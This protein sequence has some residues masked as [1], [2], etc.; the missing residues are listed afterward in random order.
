[1]PLPI[2]NRNSGNV[3]RG[4]LNLQQTNIQVDSMKRQITDEVKQ[5]HLACQRCRIDLSLAEENARSEAA[6]S[7]AA[8][9]EYFGR[10]SPNVP[11]MN[12]SLE[13]LLLAWSEYEKVEQRNLE[14]LIQYL[15]GALELNTAVGER[16][17]P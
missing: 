13:S 16:I 8:E 7:R 14:I 6:R 9:R 5:V 15:R 1:M 2:Y 11:R 10:P 17:M 12:S 4:E 3:S